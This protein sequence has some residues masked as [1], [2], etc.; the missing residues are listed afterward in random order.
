MSIKV[1]IKLDKMKIR[2]YL[3]SNDATIN[4]IENYLK[5]QGYKSVDECLKIEAKTRDQKPSGYS[6][7]N[8]SMAYKMNGTESNKTLAIEAWIK[9]AK[10]FTNETLATAIE[11]LVRPVLPPINEDIVLPKPNMTVSSLKSRHYVTV[12]EQD[13]TAL[14]DVL[15]LVHN[16][17]SVVLDVRKQAGLES[18]KIPSDVN[19]VFE[20]ISSAVHAKGLT[21]FGLMPT[22]TS[23]NYS[24]STPMST[25]TSSIVENTST[26]KPPALVD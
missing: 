26:T 23:S 19:V 1:T 25:Y 15:K 5:K 13:K 12:F 11:D 10:H 17:E 22:P 20:E 21:V 3:E 6:L 18:D 8:Y 2:V 9:I 7:A 16:F 24:S 14:D 4:E